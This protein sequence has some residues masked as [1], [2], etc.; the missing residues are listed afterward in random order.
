M[1]ESLEVKDPAFVRAMPVCGLGVN[2]GN[3]II[4]FGG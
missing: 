1:W 2:D 4:V 3:K